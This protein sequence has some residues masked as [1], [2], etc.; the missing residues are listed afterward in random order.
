MSGRSHSVPI[1][2]LTVATYT[3]P[4]D[5]PESDGTLEWDKT[6]LVLV[7]ASA[8]GKSGLGYTYAD[9]ATATLIHDVLQKHCC[10]G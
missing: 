6:T 9:S 7:D 4:T 10:W 2:R 3:V 1:E 8:A 5:L